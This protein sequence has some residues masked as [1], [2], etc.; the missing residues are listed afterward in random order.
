M[1]LRSLSIGKRLALGFAILGLIILFQGGLGVLQL[2]KISHAIHELTSEQLPQVALIG[3]INANLMRYR[4]FAVRMTYA[5]QGRSD[6]ERYYETLSGIQKELLATEKEFERYEHSPETQQQIDVLIKLQADYMASVEESYQQALAGDI[7]AAADLAERVQNPLADQMVVNLNKLRD[8][9]N[10]DAQA[11]ASE[12]TR[13]ENFTQTLVTITVI[14]ALILIIVAAIFLTRS[15][16]VPLRQVVNTAQVIAG[17]DLT[18]RIDVNGRDEMT[19]LSRAMLQMQTELRNTITHITQSSSELASASEELSAVAEDSTSHLMRQNDEVQQAASAVTEMSAAID[20]VARN[21]GATAEA[22][23]ESARFAHEGRDRVRETVDSLRGMTTGFTHT[24]ATIEG[25]ADQS[26]DIGKVLD[27]I[28]AIADQTNLLALNAAIEAARA[29]EAGRGFAVVADEVRA[30]AHRTQE[31]TAEI[32]QMI[33]KVQS[34]TEAAVVS[35]RESVEQ[36]NKTLDI[37]EI[38]GGSLDAIYE[39][40][41]Q[42]SERNLVIA[43]AAEEQ[44]AVAR[45]VDRNIVNISDLST[46]TA[47]GSKQSAGASHELSRLAVELNNAVTRFKV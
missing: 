22:S 19:E 47:A 27:V 2:K 39:R 35:M 1:F 40:A 8:T 32:E 10:A 18:Q 42:I 33:D 41:G 21:A 17:G 30:L 5:S 12:T 16:V 34:G 44:A 23:N 11:I 6:I 24:S 46:Q 4:I 13:L 45:E 31:S 26:R 29:G 37:A 15:I 9:I 14:A 38:A 3:D 7:L 20:E 36:A 28:R 43:S 25:L